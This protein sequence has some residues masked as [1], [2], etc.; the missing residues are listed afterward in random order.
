MVDATRAR[1]PLM[2]SLRYRSEGLA[3]ALLFRLFRALP[4][5]L[6]SALGGWI[7]RF[8][9]RLL[10]RRT[11]G[12]VRRLRRALPEF[13][14][15][16]A[17]CLVREMW[18]NLGRTVAELC[19][20][21]K[22]E[23][24]EHR[25]NRIEVVGLDNLQRFRDDGP[26]GLMFSAHIANWE[27]MPLVAKACGIELNVVHRAANNPLIGRLLA[28]V[29]EPGDM[30][31]IPKGALGARRILELLEEG[32]YVGMMVDQK[33]SGGIPVPFFGQQAMTAPALAHF[34]LRFGLP[35]LPV[36]CERLSGARFRVTLLPPLKPT[37]SGDRQRDV[38]AVMLEINQMLEGW[39][40]ERPEQWFW[41]HRRWPE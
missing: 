12:A 1:V 31:Q 24:R 11:D 9:R 5:D 3:A 30:G 32:K 28:S 19:H 20:L 10:K 36:R 16:D 35:I 38:N 25:P 41:L 26:G 22:L 17:R 33:A 2:R 14:E 39:I 29:R 37:D 40:R 13:G 7:G 8:A 34:A 21:E 6:A 4:L 15:R 27:V 18:D 23:P